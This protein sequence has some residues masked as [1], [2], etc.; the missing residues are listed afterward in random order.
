MKLRNVLLA[1]ALVS[2]AVYAHHTPVTLQ[3]IDAA[4]AAGASLPVLQ[5]S[6]IMRLRADGK[7][8]YQAGHIAEADNALAKAR[9][10]LH[11]K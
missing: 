6:E 7:R 3:E 5:L 11:L 4:L 8:L 9:K 10:L 2:S 1:S